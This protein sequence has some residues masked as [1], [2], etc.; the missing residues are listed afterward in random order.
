GKHNENIYTAFVGNYLLPRK[1]KIDKRRTYLSAQ[2]REGKMTK[3]QAQDILKVPA[4]FDIND[5]GE[6][7]DYILHLVNYYPIGKR[8]HYKMTN[9]KLY[10]PLFWVL[11]KLGVVPATMFNKYC[12]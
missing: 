2:I 8:E 7:K 6:R 12:K 4:N 9:Y 5:L 10:K 3:F 11:M 1:F